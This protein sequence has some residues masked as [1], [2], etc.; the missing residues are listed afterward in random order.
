MSCN[1][2]MMALTSARR[3]LRRATPTL[4]GSLKTY[5]FNSC[6]NI[7]GSYGRR[8]LPSSMG[9]RAFY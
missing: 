5:S 6:S 9:D 7:D 8:C 3:C 1:D 4:G 2:S